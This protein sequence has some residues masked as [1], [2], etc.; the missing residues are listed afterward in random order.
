[1]K[2]SSILSMAYAATMILT[3]GLPMAAQAETA[4]RYKNVS[5]GFCLD[6]NAEGKAYTM[7]CNG[8]NYQNWIRN[9]RT[10]VNVST[11][12]CLDSNANGQLYTMACN[13]GN[14]QNWVGRG[15][16]FV[17]VATGF[18]LDSNGEGRA[19]TMACNGGNYQNWRG[20]TQEY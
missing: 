15:K 2:V 11:G 18:C 9:G 5:T 16:R 4:N 19:Y 8:G 6:S 12:F 7:A 3:I 10:L 13:G 20:E 1:M 17:N 14:Y